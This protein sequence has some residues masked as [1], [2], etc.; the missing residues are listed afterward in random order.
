MS[1]GIIPF[2]AIHHW[3]DIERERLAQALSAPLPARIIGWDESGVGLAVTCP[4]CRQEHRHIVVP[5]DWTPNEPLQAACGK[6]AY[7]VAIENAPR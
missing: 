4:Y 3:Q 5:E 1:H 7:Y 6:G 2:G